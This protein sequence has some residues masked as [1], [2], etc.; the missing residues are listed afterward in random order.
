MRVR[1][2]LA[3]SAAIA[4]V[5]VGACVDLFHGTDF[6]TLCEREPASAACGDVQ[7]ATPDGGDDAAPAET[8]FCALTAGEVDA[9]A[10]RSCAYL[11]ACAGAMDDSA[12]GPCV[13][14]ARFVMD[15]RANPSYRPTGDVEEAWRCLSRASSCA[16]VD[17]CVFGGPPPTCDTGDGGA[18]FVSCGRGGAVDVRVDC[19]VDGERP[20]AVDVCALHGRRC[21]TTRGGVSRCASGA[22]EACATLGAYGCVGSSIVDCRGDAGVDHGVD[23]SGFGAGGCVTSPSGNA[24][25]A[26]VADAPNCSASPLQ[27]TGNVVR[28]C[29][30]G[31]QVTL[32]CSD[33]G[34]TCVSGV[35]PTQEISLPDGGARSAPLY[36]PRSFCVTPECQTDRCD[37][38]GNL[39]ACV[40]GRVTQVDCRA[41]DLGA[42]TTKNGRAS[43]GKP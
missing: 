8:D 26:P 34:L 33:F 18:A 2:L 41:L 38:K 37:E 17:A 10:R 40:F 39:E 1:L 28:G 27:C 23:C 15:C 29:V 11:G 20:S 7:H 43:C 3:A 6:A 9:L 36:D 25:C 4:V 35:Y 42:C 16:A 21:E 22:P 19:T 14:Q 30:Q 32:N 5:T 12:F 13:E 31:R 24:A